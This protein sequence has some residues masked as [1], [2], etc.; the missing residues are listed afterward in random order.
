MANCSPT[1]CITNRMLWVVAGL[2]NIAI[3]IVDRRGWPGWSEV[4]YNPDCNL[5]CTSLRSIDLNKEEGEGKRG[6]FSA[7]VGF[8]KANRTLLILVVVR[9]YHIIHVSFFCFLK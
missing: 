9:F 1:D 8:E 5:S 7:R 6:D 4:D 3:V 2:D